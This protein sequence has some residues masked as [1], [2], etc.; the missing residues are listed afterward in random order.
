MFGRKPIL[1]TSVALIFISYFALSLPSYATP[2]AG[3]DT[4][5]QIR[6]LGV[7]I[8]PPPSNKTINTP[9]VYEMPIKTKTSDVH[10]TF[11]DQTAPPLGV[12]ITPLP[13]QNSVNQS[14]TITYAPQTQLILTPSPDAQVSIGADVSPERPLGLLMDQSTFTP[15]VQPFMDAEFQKSMQDD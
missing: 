11:P 2:P 15:R 6:P 4:I 7:L 8:A 12:L 10:F 14:S 9:D 5:S 13:D 3:I 1:M